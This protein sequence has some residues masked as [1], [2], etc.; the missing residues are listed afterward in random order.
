MK[1]IIQALIPQPK[2]NEKVF[3]DL[4][5]VQNWINSCRNEGQLMCCENAIN[6]F[7]NKYQDL[8]TTTPKIVE[9]LR[10]LVINKYHELPTIRN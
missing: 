8:K 1:K 7:G 9:H 5:V 4:G 3:R 6:N 2:N 10:T